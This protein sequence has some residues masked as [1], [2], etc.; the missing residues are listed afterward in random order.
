MIGNPPYVDIKGLDNEIVK[1]LFD[2]F[3]SAN[4][5]VNLYSSFIERSVGLMNKKGCFSFIIPSSLLTQESYKDLRSLLLNNTSIENIVRLPNE[6]FGGS[7]GDVK[8]DT[9]I[10][11]SKAGILDNAQAD[12]IIYKGFDRINEIS[13]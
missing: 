5:R 1:Y 13:N 4:N 12:I 10:L 9:I 8:V 7:A 2:S 6:S 11:T 3:K